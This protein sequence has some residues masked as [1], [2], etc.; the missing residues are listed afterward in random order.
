MTDEMDGGNGAIRRGLSDLVWSTVVPQL[1]G[2]AFCGVVA[3]VAW[4]F[5]CLPDPRYIALM[6]ALFAAK[7][8]GELYREGPPR[9]LGAVAALFALMTVALL[10]AATAD[11]AFP[12]GADRALGF[13][14]GFLVG[15]PVGAAV[16]AWFYNRAN[17]A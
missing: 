17:V 3:L 12:A 16:L 13:L 8:A 10:V 15:T 6:T 14:A 2:L 7:P 1:V 4:P 9:R 5:G 11:W